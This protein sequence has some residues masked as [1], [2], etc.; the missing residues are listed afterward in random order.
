N[1]TR[2]NGRIELIEAKLKTRSF[3]VD[4][5]TRLSYQP[6]KGYGIQMKENYLWSQ[7]RETEIFAEID[8]SGFLK[9]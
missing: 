8:G 4:R 3:I 2:K 5:D 9:K 6:M 1:I 7:A